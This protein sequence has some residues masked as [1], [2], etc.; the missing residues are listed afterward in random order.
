MT[1]V[2]ASVSSPPPVGSGAERH[3]ESADAVERRRR[4]AMLAPAPNGGSGQ[5]GLCGPDLAKVS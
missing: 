2:I 5:S 1:S 4:N 3:V